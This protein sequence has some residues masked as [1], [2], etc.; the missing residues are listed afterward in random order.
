MNI[1]FVLTSHDQMGDTNQKTGFWLE[2]FATPYYFLKDAGAK[3][4][5]SSPLG[6]MPPID[7][8]SESNDFQ[9]ISTHRLNNDKETLLLLQK[10]VPL[11]TVQAEDFDAVFYPGGHGPLWDLTSDTNSIRL[12]ESFYMSDKPIA[13]VCHAPAVLLNAKTPQ[14]TS[15][16]QNRKVT[17][18]SNTEETAVALNDVVPFMLEDELKEQGGDYQRDD[19]WSSF[20]IK[21]GLIITGQNPASSEATASLLLNSIH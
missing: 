10:T 8:K 13:A 7:P 12:I 1:L 9:T 19:D 14:E 6:G 17:G 16:L 11:S 15:I 18:F 3:I 5:L 4:T 2:E 21:D 20:A